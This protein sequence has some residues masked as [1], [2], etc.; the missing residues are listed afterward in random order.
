MKMH[1]VTLLLHLTLKENWQFSKDFYLRVVGPNLVGLNL[2]LSFIWT[3]LKIF[4]LTTTFC[5]L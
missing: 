4:A 2:E 1:D 3:F 5:Y